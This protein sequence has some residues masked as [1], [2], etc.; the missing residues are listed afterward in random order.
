MLTVKR[1]TVWLLE[2][3][4]EV[5]LAAYLL[6][7]VYGPNN[8]ERFPG[9]WGNILFFAGFVSIYYTASLYLLSCFYFGLVNRQKEDLNHVLLMTFAFTV[10][11]L[12]FFFL[13]GLNWGGKEYALAVFGICI[14]AFAHAVGAGVRR[15]I[16]Y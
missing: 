8:D 2:R 16:N 9:F 6:L 3:G 14:V 13:F 5:G 10:H 4:I 7:V 11:A 12:A 1:F 15:A